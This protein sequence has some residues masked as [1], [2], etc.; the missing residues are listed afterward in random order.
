MGIKVS[1]FDF[2]PFKLAMLNKGHT[3]EHVDACFAD[4]LILLHDAEDTG[5]T[6][7]MTEGADSAF[8]F[9]VSDTAGLLRLSAAVHGVGM[10]MAHNP[11][12]Y[13]TMEFDAAWDNTCAAFARHGIDLPADYQSDRGGFRSAASCIRETVR[14]VDIQQAA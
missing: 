2:S 3:Q 6:H 1:N 10:V 4:L 12:V 8:H 13:G 14:I 5:R 11:H 7:A 9:I